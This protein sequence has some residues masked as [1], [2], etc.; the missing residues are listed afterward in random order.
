VGKGEI[1]R[2][3]GE[4]GRQDVLL[5]G[6]GD[7]WQGDCYS[8]RQQTRVP[9]FSVIFSGWLSSTFD[10]LVALRFGSAAVRMVERGEFGSMVSLDPPLMKSVL[11]EDVIRMIRTVPGDSDSIQTAR[12]IGICLG[13]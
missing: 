2:G 5:G 13:D 11:L 12:D 3:A 7:M 10:R 6:V 4:I 1:T 9:L 8:Y